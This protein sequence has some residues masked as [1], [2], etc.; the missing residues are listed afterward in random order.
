M[1]FLVNNL[2]LASLQHRSSS[3][4][5]SHFSFI[6]KCP[7]VA[8]IPGHV[9][10]PDAELELLILFFQHLENCGPVSFGLH[11]FRWILWHSNWCSSI[12]KHHFSPAVFKVFFFSSALSLVFKRVIMMCL[13][14]RFLWEYP[15]WGLF[16]FQN[17]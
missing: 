4:I 12:G 6:W 1:P 15:V 8:F 3:K 16:C 14:H 7:H 9:V 11:G 13:W 10:S 2:C 5:F 17:L